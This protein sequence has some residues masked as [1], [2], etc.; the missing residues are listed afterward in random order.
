MHGVLADWQISLRASGRSLAT[1][2]SYLTVGESIAGYLD[3]AGLPTAVRSIKREDVERYLG[4]M[5]HR[6]L[7][8][9]TVAKHY[10]SLQQLFKWLSEDGEIDRSP[11]DRR[12]SGLFHDGFIDC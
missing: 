4:D 12:R 2:S 3:V 11:P 5:R 8:P 1:I 9:A 10:R 7:A 6:G